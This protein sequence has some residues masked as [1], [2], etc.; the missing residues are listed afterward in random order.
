MRTNKKQLVAKSETAIT[1]SP[2][3]FTASDLKNDLYNIAQLAQKK[4]ADPRQFNAV[5]CAYRA[6]LSTISLEMKAKKLG[7]N[8]S[9]N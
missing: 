5:I 8:I 2:S 9:G 7:V 3:K 4:N 1:I 6:I